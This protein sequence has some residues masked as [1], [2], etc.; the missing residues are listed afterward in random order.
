MHDENSDDRIIPV[1]HKLEEYLLSYIQE[2]GFDREV[3]RKEPLFR[4]VKR[5]EKGRP[6]SARRLHRTDALAMVKRRAKK[7]GFD[8]RAVINHT[9]R[10][11]GIST[12]LENDGKLE[13]AQY[14]A[15]HASSRTTKLYDR[16]QK[17]ITVSEI[18]R[19]RFTK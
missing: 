7:A 5:H 17:N 2:A 3:D 18:E 16:R 11:S 10:G 13:D 14:I 1:H 4:S 15:G 8:P 9:F 19:I 12:F 6:L